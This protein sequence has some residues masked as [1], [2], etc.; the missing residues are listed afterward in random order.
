[1]HFPTHLTFP[2]LFQSFARV[3]VGI[4][5]IFLLP[6][7][8]LQAQNHPNRIDFI[9]PDGLIYPDVTFAGIKGGIPTN[10]P[11]VATVSSTTANDRQAILNGIAAASQAGGGV[12]L[13]QNGQYDLHDHVIITQSNIVIRGQSRKNTVIRIRNATD[14]FGLIWFDGR[15]RMNPRQMVTQ[16][17]P[18]GSRRLFLPPADLVTHRRFYQT[19][20]W[21]FVS[22]INEAAQYRDKFRLSP[23]SGFYREMSKITAVGPNYIDVEQPFRV[24][25]DPSQ[26]AYVEPIEVVTNVGV[27]N[28]TMLGDSTRLPANGIQFD[29]TVNGWVKDVDIIRPPSYPVGYGYAK[30]IEIRDCYFK[31]PWHDGGGGV[32]YGGFVACFDCLWENT[33]TDSM[34]HAPLIQGFA[35]GCVIKNSTFL[36]SDAHWHTGWSR[37]NIFDNIVV[38]KGTSGKPYLFDTPMPDNVQ[39]DPIGAMHVV[40]NSDFHGGIWGTG[41]KMGAFAES[42]VFA[43]NRFHSPLFR[44]PPTKSMI[45]IFDW[46]RDT[47]FYN[48]VF[49]TNNR[50]PRNNSAFAMYMPGYEPG[51]GQTGTWVHESLTPPWPL[52]TVTSPSIPNSSEVHFLMNQIY[53]INPARG[54]VGEGVPVTEIDNQFFP[55]PTTAPARPVAPVP[56]IHDWEL[57]I[58]GTSIIG[59]SF[60]VVLSFFKGEAVPGAIQLLWET[61]QE[62]NSAAFEIERSLDGRLFEQVGIVPAAGNASSPQFYTFDDTRVEPNQVY[63]YRLRMVDLDGSFEWSNTVEVSFS[64]QTVIQVRVGPNPVKETLNVNVTYT[65]DQAVEVVLYDTNGAEIYTRSLVDGLAR[66]NVLLEMGKLPAALYFVVVKSPSRVLYQSRVMKID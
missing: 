25:I 60:P 53:G 63:Y 20:K 12:V 17:S 22:V 21:V 4:L 29:W 7:S 55:Q 35:S 27:E 62:E 40:Y 52:H 42:W 46:A 64:D 44:S 8:S 56:S 41:I 43:H 59:G 14:K 11:V 51:F 26:T 5:L 3:A 30:H 45:E 58:K 18:R 47:Y 65:G 66:Q 37:E 54:F 33:N 24:D 31:N 10:L 49:W 61:A 23:V 2:V 32:G 50:D 39:H 36:N 13:L 16:F 19:G 1:M 48:N 9:G 15:G 34:R 6:Q 57:Q 28:L 38:Q